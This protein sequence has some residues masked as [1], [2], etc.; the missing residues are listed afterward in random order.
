M[1][2]PT[3][4]DAAL[5]ILEGRLRELEAKWPELKP[6]NDKDIAQ[7]R[8]YL[9]ADHATAALAVEALREMPDFLYLV[10]WF[11]G[12]LAYGKHADESLGERTNKWIEN[13]LKPMRAKVKD[14]LARIEAA[15]G[16]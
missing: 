3:G 9:A 10:D 14:A 16:E 8:A 1:T 7:A 15:R 5:I 13:D 4:A 6:E 12:A 2:I 11:M